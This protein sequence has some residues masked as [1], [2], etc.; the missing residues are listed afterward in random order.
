MYRRANL[1]G[2]NPLVYY[3]EGEHGGRYTRV[4]EGWSGPARTH[5][6]V[7]LLLLS[8]SMGI[9][10]L[11]ISSYFDSRRLS[12]FTL[13][14]LDRPPPSNPATLSRAVYRFVEIHP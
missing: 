8:F 5:Q 12:F 7:Y 11:V 3:L 9:Y 6:R 2:V 10:D 13:G 1:T 4:E 14:L